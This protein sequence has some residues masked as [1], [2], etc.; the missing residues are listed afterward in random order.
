MSDVPDREAI[1]IALFNLVRARL[2]ISYPDLVLTSITRRMVMPTEVDELAQPYL[3][4]REHD[5][6][7]V[8]T[9][10]GLP[11][12][13]VFHWFVVGYFRIPGNDKT[14]SGATILNP[15]L[16]AVENAFNADNSAVNTITLPVNGQDLAYYAQVDGAVVK[17]TGDIDPNGQGFFVMP[18]KLISA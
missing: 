14:V 13:H 6:Q 3:I 12:K 5:E 15:F 7:I 1:A 17:E 18:V 9:G 4:L 10:R 16:T 11:P 2:L 8:N